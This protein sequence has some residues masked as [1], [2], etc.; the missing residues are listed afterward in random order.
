[1]IPISLIV[2]IEMVKT[3]QGY[4]IT[5][6]SFMRTAPNK[7]EEPRTAKA[8]RSSLNEELGMIEYVFTDKTG[9]L[10]RNEMVMKNL[11][12]GTQLYESESSS[13]KFVSS[14]LER[15]ME[16]THPFQRP[17]QLSPKAKITNQMEII[18]MFLFA[19]SVCH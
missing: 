2:S 12:I 18:E 4:F 19:V 6:D 5:H 13:A 9:T 14:K 3:I 16:S 11:V 10:T 17:I 1:M 7:S 15:D 8:F